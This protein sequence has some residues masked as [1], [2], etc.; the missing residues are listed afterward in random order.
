[1]SWS[2]DGERLATG[3]EDGT[4]RVWGAANAGAVQ[5]WALQDQAREELLAR[6]AFS[7]HAAGFIQTWLLLLPLPLASEETNAQALDRQQVPGEVQLRPR[8]GEKVLV[9]GRP[10]AW[11]EHRSPEAAVNFNAVLGQ[12]TER[13]VAYAVCYIESDRARD[14]LWLQVGCDQRAKVSLNGEPIHQSRRDRFRW[15]LD[16]AGPVALKQGINVLVLKVVNREG[17]WGGCVRLVDDA[18][19]PAQGFRVKLTP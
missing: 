12:V 15:D 19:R 10:L 17:D 9:G 13:S 8:P 7:P 5:E 1:V 4:A 16:T 14:G 6:N 3:S 11:Q 18:G 2:P